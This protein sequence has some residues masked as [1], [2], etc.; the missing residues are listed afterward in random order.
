MK[1]AIFFALIS[2]L[3]ASCATRDPI[4]VKVRSTDLSKAKARA[5]AKY[6]DAVGRLSKELGREAVVIRTAETIDRKRVK[7]RRPSLGTSQ[8]GIH[9]S[10]YYVT[11]EG[12]VTPE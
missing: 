8:T 1:A 9:K 6:D 5:E 10:Y 12:A 7:L 2:L 4:Q 11:I 3:L